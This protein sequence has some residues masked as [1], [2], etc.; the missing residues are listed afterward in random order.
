[1]RNFGSAR[2][3]PVVTRVTPAKLCM[4]CSLECC[5]C[6]RSATLNAVTPAVEAPPRQ[7]GQSVE[8]YAPGETLGGPR[9]PML[10]MPEG[11][12]NEAAHLPASAQ[13]PTLRAT[14]ASEAAGVLLTKMLKMPHSRRVS[15]WP[16]G[17]LSKSCCITKCPILF[18]TCISGSVFLNV[19]SFKGPTFKKSKP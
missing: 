10:P 19:P 2:V 18:K 3:L 15:L 7:A 13:Q 11:L 4:F 6:T 8:K 1:M 16:C 12:T 5:L 9:V 17:H 14:G